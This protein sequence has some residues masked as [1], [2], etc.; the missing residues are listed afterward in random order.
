MRSPA[1]A[2]NFRDE[3]VAT[4]RLALPLV[5]GQLAAIALNFIDTL[6]AGRH[7]GYALASVAEGAAVWS[8]VIVTLIGLMFALPPTVAQLVGANRRAEVS[9]IALQAGWIALIAGVFLFVIVRFAAEPL[10]YWI[11]VQANLIPGVMAFLKPYSFGAPALGLFLAC[12]GLSEGIGFS[13]PV[14]WV[15]AA[16]VLILLPTGFAL[17][18]GRFG[19]PNMG[20]AGLGVA[21]AITLWMQALLFV[22][23]IW[24]NSHYQVER[25]HFKFAWPQWKPI[26]DL[27]KLGVPMGISVFM[28]AS[29]FVTT[30]LLMGRFGEQ[31]AGAHQ[32]AI[33]LGSVAFMVPLGI[34]MAATVR[35]GQAAGANNIIGVRRAARAAFLLM[36]I[37]QSISIGLMILIP[38]S[39][40]GMYSK[41]PRVVQMAVILIGLLAIFQLSDGIQAIAG[42]VLRGLKDTLWPAIITVTS[43]WAVGMSIGYVLAFHYN[44][45]ARG[46]WY[47]LN[48]GLTLAAILL[49]VRFV[50]LLRSLRWRPLQA[51]S[52]VA[53]YRDESL[54]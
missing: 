37:A 35:V 43:Y 10:L 32:I 25:D 3:L 9:A 2:L 51:T 4:T 6:L 12:K 7:S 49:I 42:G 20:A 19:L 38:E 41:D 23:V 28:E 44:W 24:K 31:A 27:L 30:A 14:M 47:G 54:S 17:V 34:A 22:V 11:G 52:D 29:L 8:L 1:V 33:N 48:A 16:G 46:L 40:A 21:S 13:K 5:L 26:R 18:F 53:K 39:L 36:L 45:N 15:G 50:L